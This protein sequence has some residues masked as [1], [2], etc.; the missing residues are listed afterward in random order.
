LQFINY[1]TKY[2]QKPKTPAKVLLELS[3]LWIDSKDPEDIVK[4][5]KKNILRRLKD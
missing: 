3:G 5:L 1:L 2:C 4:I